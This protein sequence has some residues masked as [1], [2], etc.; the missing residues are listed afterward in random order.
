MLDAKKKWT[1][2]SSLYTMRSLKSASMDGNLVQCRLP[3]VRPFCSQDIENFKRS[4]GPFKSY[5]RMPE[6]CTGPWDRDG[7]GWQLPHSNYTS[8]LALSLWMERGFRLRSVEYFAGVAMSMCHV[9]SKFRCA[10]PRFPGFLT[11]TGKTW[12]NPSMQQCIRMST[13]HL[14]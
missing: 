4:I 14:G 5:F 1:P 8:D 10:W 9:V 6:D 11:M 3:K 2:S 13:H 7:P 12:K